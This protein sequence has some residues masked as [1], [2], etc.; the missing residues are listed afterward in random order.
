LGFAIHERK[1]GVARSQQ[2]LYI[3]GGR[4]RSAT[5]AGLR[6]AP[7]ANLQKGS[8]TYAESSYSDDAL[9]DLTLELKD[10]NPQFSA[11]PYGFIG[12]SSQLSQADVQESIRN[13]G[14]SDPDIVW[15]GPEF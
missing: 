11:V 14:V 15:T 3:N 4:L 7:A 2:L 6:S 10:V 1:T 8:Y 5:L 13:T 9:V 12:A